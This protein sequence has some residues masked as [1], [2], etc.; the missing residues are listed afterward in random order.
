MNERIRNIRKELGMT[1]D[2]FS[3]YINL[4]RNFIT[5]IETGAKKPSDRT[6]QD[7]CRVFNVSENW[8][9]TGEGEMFVAKTRDE[10]LAE[11]AGNVLQADDDDFKKRFVAMLSKLSENE[12]KVL[13]QMAIDLTK[14]KKDG[15]GA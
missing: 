8:L 2:E 10:Q 9:L 5:Q 14:D 6:I 13:E 11:W 1:Q 3:A 7:I 4:S 12:W 15:D